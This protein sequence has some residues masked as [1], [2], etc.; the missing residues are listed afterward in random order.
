M[1]INIRGTNGAGKST[2]V[3]RVMEARGPWLGILG[4][5]K[6][7]IGYQSTKSNIA[8]VGPYETPTGGCDNFSAKGIAD[9]VMSTI[10]ELDRH[11]NHVIFEGVIISMYGIDRL[12][13]LHRATSGL[14]II[15]LTT[16]I[17]QCEADINERRVV[18]MRNYKPLKP[19]LVADKVV[20]IS[21]NTKKLKAI[22]VPVERLDRE[23]AFQRVLELVDVS[24]GD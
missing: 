15:E 4:D 10:A 17:E 21:S 22:G 18:S 13:R 9:W 11:Q 20:S 16:P 2:L 5:K 12:A 8:V 6:K 14:H 23:S 3:R 24:Y 7:P 19:G 1:L